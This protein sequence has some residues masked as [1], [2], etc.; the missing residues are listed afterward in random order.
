[1]VHAIEA[2]LTTRLA[3]ATP[4][5]NYPGHRL[6]MASSQAVMFDADTA[7]DTGRD[8]L[9]PGQQLLS[10]PVKALCLAV[11]TVSWKYHFTWI[12]ARA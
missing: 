2:A 1:M 10:M 7:R 11:S 6:C 9:R 5:T 8:R 3:T 4:S 12:H